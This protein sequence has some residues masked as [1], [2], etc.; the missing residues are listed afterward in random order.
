MLNRWAIPLLAVLA[1]SG[2]GAPEEGAE[3]STSAEKEA[4]LRQWIADLNS[5]DPEVRRAAIENLALF[6]K[7]YGIHGAPRGNWNR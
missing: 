3:Q 7:G 2:C 1:L 6:Q 4:L 5:P